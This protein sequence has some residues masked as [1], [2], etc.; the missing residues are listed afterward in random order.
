MFET[1]QDAI[2][3]G[4]YTSKVKRRDFCE[5]MQLKMEEKDFVE[6]LIFCDIPYMCGCRSQLPLSLRRGSAAD[7]L[8]KLRVRIPRGHKCLS[9]VRIVF[10][11]VEV[12]A[13]G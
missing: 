7:R 6:R 8:L 5:E 13:T 2:G 4:P 10:C 11:Q 12:S 9:L 1:V 3:A